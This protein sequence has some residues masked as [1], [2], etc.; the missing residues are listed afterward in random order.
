[1]L[2]AINQLFHHVES[3]D[4]V[5]KSTMT[6]CNTKF[7]CRICK[8][9]HLLKDCTGI[10]QVVEVWS[11][12]SQPAS[13]TVAD[14]VGDKPSTSD[15]QVGSKRGKVKL[16]CLLCME[17]HRNYLFP[18]MDDDSY[19]LENIVDVQQQLPSPNPQL[20]DE[21]FNL[22][23]SSVNLVDQV[24]NLVPSSVESVYQVIDSISPSIDP[25]LPL[26]S[27]VKVVDLIPP[28]VYPTPLRK[29]E[30]VA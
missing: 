11:R 25:T 5:D 29:I 3:V 1:M 22:V 24:V 14:H 6:H 9:D 4:N 16:P 15:N 27:E 7:P 30:D 18:H 28:L 8:G 19:M 17:M 12:G 2:E 23:P 26:E 21:L 13:S 20:V 10:S